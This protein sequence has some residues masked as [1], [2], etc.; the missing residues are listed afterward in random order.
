MIGESI[1][2]FVLIFLFL[3]ITSFYLNNFSSI[4]K[5]ITIRPFVFTGHKY[6]Q[7]GKPSL[8][9]LVEMRKASPMHYAHKVYAPTLLQIGLEDK[10]V[11]YFNGFEHYHRLRANG[12]KVK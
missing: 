6:S 4:I 7:V 2:Y 11:S 12:V 10:R 1:F 9:Q 3:L 5:F 8:D